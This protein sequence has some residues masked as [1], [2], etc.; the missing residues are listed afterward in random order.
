MNH[1]GRPLKSELN[2]IL[3]PTVRD[4]AWAAGVYEGEGH[5]NKLGITAMSQKEKWLLDRIRDL[6]GGSVGGPYKGSNNNQHYLW[7][8]AGPRS[9]GFLMTIYLFLSPHRKEQIRKAL[10]L[11]EY[12]IKAGN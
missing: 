11:G 4:I 6:F 10:K 12:R 9:R 8:L 2:P 3:S 7:Q 5:A 1:P